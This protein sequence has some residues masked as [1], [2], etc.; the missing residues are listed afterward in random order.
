VL[1]GAVYQPVRVVGRLDFETRNMAIGGGVL[2]EMLKQID[3]SRKGV[4][5]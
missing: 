4:V 1:L 2:D 5:L 3:C